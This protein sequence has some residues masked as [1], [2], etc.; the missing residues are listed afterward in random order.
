MY[1]PT[2]T[3]GARYCSDFHVYAIPKGR[4]RTAGLAVTAAAVR[5]HSSRHLGQQVGI[6]TRPRLLRRIPQDRKCPLAFESLG[7]ARH[8]ADVARRND[9]LET[10]SM[11]TRSR[12]DQFPRHPSNCCP[13]ELTL[14]YVR[15][16]FHIGDRPAIR[17]R[18]PR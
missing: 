18:T 11:T 15:T 3:P 6:A 14:D 1:Q 8:V 12:G 17:G 9:R 10:R 2:I 13:V 5:A 4:A 7:D 16:P